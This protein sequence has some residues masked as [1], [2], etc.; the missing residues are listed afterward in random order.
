[1]FEY[2]IH[3]MNEIKLDFFG[4][5]LSLSVCLSF[6]PSVCLSVSVCLS[7]CPSVCLTLSFFLSVCLSIYL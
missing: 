6:S 3:I 7:I 1:M 5:G 4:S 2:E